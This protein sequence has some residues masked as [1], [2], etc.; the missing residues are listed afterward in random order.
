MSNFVST[1]RAL[2]EQMT[3]A[4]D[5]PV[6]KVHFCATH[7]EH[8]KFGPGTCISEAH[9][10]PDAEG[11][12]AWY[13]VEFADGVRKMN[14]VDLKIVM[15]ESHGHAKKKAMKEEE[16]G[17]VQEAEELE[18]LSKSTLGSYVKKASRDVQQN[19]YRSG[20][21]AARG[22]VN[23]PS[24]NKTQKRQTGIAKA[25]DRLTSEEFEELDELDKSTLGSYVKKASRDVQ[26]NTYRSGLSAARGV[27]NEPSISKTQK[28]QQGIAKAVDRLTSEDIEQTNEAQTSA[29]A[30]YAKA[31][32]SQQASTTMKGMD[33]VGKEDKDI[34]NDGKTDKSD[35]YLHNRRKAI[36]AA[37]KE[38]IDHELVDVITT[39]EMT[40]QIAIPVS[41]T[42]QD[43]LYAVK[44][45]VNNDTEETQSQI[46]ALAQEAYENQEIDILIN[47]E[48]RAMNEAGAIKIPTATGMRVMGTRYGNSAETERNRTKRFIDTMK[49]PSTKAMDSLEKPAKA[50]K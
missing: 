33:S 17:S 2:M 11:N 50:K 22:V 34:N 35:S 15:G 29:A 5:K 1:T 23:N 36:K 6:D 8:A 28:R 30:R 45:L 20:L 3:K 13:T 24:I 7:V 44:V 21:S 39:F 41:P 14:T 48:I 47:A 18:E 9:A 25:V 46:I 27:T 26:Q 4:Q 19:T 32:M 42:F 37:M 40:E 49:G 31:K 16:Q 43:Y 10:E 12:I 38:A